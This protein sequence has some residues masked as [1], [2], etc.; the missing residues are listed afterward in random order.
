[1]NF[2]ALKTTALSLFMLGVFAVGTSQTTKKEIKTNK[3]EIAWVGKKLT[4][5]HDG[6]IAVQSGYMN[7]EN[8]LLVGG[9]LIIDM[10]SIEVEDLSGDSKRDLENHLKSDDFFGVSSFPVAI[11]EIVKAVHKGG[12]NYEVMA[13]LTIKGITKSINFNL[14]AGKKYATADFKIDRAQYNVRYGSKTF[15]SDLGDKFI[16]DKFDISAT[17]R[18]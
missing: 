3:S 8:N 10:T 2:K 4:G 1:M 6:T 17:I 11:L 14:M 18:F 13:N 15:F 16:E 7:F 12:D 9:E 5:E